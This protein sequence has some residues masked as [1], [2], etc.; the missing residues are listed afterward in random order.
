MVD[1][2][3]IY[4]STKGPRLISQCT[5]LWAEVVCFILYQ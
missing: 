5:L 2:Y 4:V 3:A 1:F